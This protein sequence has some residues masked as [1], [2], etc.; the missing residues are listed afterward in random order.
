MCVWGGGGVAVL[1]NVR[2]GQETVA[3][4]LDEFGV[5]TVVVTDDLVQSE[6]KRKRASRTGHSALK[7]SS[8]HAI[9]DTS[10]L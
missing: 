6:G 4:L 7:V 2:A 3:M 9:S 10:L 5:L 8:V 1:D